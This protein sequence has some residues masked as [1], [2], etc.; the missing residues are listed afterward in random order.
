MYLFRRNNGAAGSTQAVLLYQNCSEAK[1]Q[2]KHPIKV[3]VWAAISKRGRS[4]ICIFEGCMDAKGYIGI[5]EKTL[6]P[7]I[8]KLY[9][10][11]HRFV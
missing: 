9:P 1:V 8:E 5:L 11:G 2:A 7:M 6:I 4:G 3:H 10:D